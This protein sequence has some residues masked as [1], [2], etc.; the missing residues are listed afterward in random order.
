M[1][2]HSVNM[3][4]SNDGIRNI[5]VVIACLLWRVFPTMVAMLVLGPYL[6]ILLDHHYLDKG[7]LHS[8]LASSSSRHQH[9]TVKH[10]HRDWKLSAETP[11]FHKT[12][13]VN[14]SFCSEYECTYENAIPGPT[15]YFITRLTQK[16]L[17]QKTYPY[18]EHRPPIF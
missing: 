10:N 18:P 9:F 4:A 17:L 15:G 2:N 14:S 11:S 5:K 7:P 13:A 8:H 1:F 3:N 6:G 12:G 16:D